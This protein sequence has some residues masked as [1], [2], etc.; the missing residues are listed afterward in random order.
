MVHVGPE[1]VMGT[2][3]DSQLAIRSAPVGSVEA[4]KMLEDG[5]ADLAAALK[6]GIEVFV[7]KQPGGS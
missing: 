6:A 7:E 2:D 4:E 5:V 3:F 1:G